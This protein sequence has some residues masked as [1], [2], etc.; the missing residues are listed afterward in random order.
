MPDLPSRDQWIPAL[1]DRLT[2]ERAGRGGDAAVADSSERWSLSK[3]QLRERV[4]RDLGWLLNA[5]AMFDAWDPILPDSPAVH[6]VI[7]YG[8]PAL[9]GRLLPDVDI[10]LFEQTIRQAIID[11]EPRIIPETLRVDAQPA[12]DASGSTQGALGF[13]IIAELRAEPYPI[14]LLLRTV[15]DL[16]TGEVDVIPADARALRLPGEPDRHRAPGWMR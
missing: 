4:V 13:G 10:R 6:S 11:F 16:D 9:S 12:L 14:E 8:M 7:N 5:Q 2:D 15:L 3:Q 1:L